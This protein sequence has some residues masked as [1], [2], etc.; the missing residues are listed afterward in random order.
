M[1][2]YIE[3]A[4]ILV[5]ILKPVLHLT[6]IYQIS[7]CNTCYLFPQALRHVFPGRQL[8]QRR[9]HA[10]VHRDIGTDGGRVGCALQGGAGY[11]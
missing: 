7:L 1:Q 3:M 10:Q 6:L 4:C 9:N 8:P 2:A 11:A 5:L